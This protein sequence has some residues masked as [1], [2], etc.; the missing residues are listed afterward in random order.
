[1]L[2][3]H[4]GSKSIQASGVYGFAN[5]HITRVNKYH[6]SV[7]M[8]NWARFVQDGLGQH[9]KVSPSSLNGARL[10]GWNPTERFEAVGLRK[11]RRGQSIAAGNSGNVISVG[12]GR[13]VTGPL[14]GL[15]MELF[16]CHVEKR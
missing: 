14:G 8:Q 7:A 15:V 4:S 9:H 11:R 12:G 2:F 1:M 3:T 16:L 13:L 6:A 5:R 10:V